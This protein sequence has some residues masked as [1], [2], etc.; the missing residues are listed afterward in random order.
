VV[1]FFG[2]DIGGAHLKL[3]RLEIAG[4]GR[5]AIRT[6][7]VPFEIWKAPGDLTARLRHLLGSEDPGGDSSGSRR[8]AAASPQR[9]PHGVTMTAEL[10]DVFPTKTEGVRSVLRSCEAALGCASVLVLN[11]EGAFL[12]L[13]EARERPLTV[14]AANWSACAH[15]IARG[16][17]PSILVDV[18]STTTDIIPIRNDGPVAI[19]RTDTERLMSGEL[20]YTGTLRTLPA[21]LT[22]TVPLRGRPC[23]VTSEYFCVMADVYRVLGRIDE[24]DYSVATPDG[25]GKDR[26]ESAA[27]L[28]RL[29]CADHGELTDAEIRGIAADLERRQIDRIAHGVREVT[30]RHPDLIDRPLVLAGVGSFLARE[31]AALLGRRAIALTDLLPDVEGGDWDRAAPSAAIALLLARAAGASVPGLR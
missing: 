25:R 10:S 31:S 5:A 18:G 6:R 16:T 17:G 21:S 11:S 3:S 1:V 19:G 7:I 8:D 28:A 2:W 29:V 15:L 14:A 30:E 22:E 26:R 23:R 20:V 27:R 12:P 24:S 4:E 9:A 13:G